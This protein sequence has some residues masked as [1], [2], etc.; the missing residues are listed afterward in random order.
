MRIE[1]NTSAVVYG[2][3]YKPKNQEE[4]KADLPTLNKQLASQEEDLSNLLKK[5]EGF[6]NTHAL[7]S[8]TTGL[9]QH[10]DNKA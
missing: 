7:I 5:I 3:N 6:G 4:A 8:K 2:N 1:S 10:F 9:G